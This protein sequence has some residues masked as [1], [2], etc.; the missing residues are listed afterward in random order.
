MFRIH[1]IITDA[2]IAYDFQI[3]QCIDQR[4][5]DSRHAGNALH[6]ARP[7]RIDQCRVAARDAAHRKLAGQ[8]FDGIFVEVSEHQNGCVAFGHDNIP[9]DSFGQHIAVREGPA[10]GQ[11]KGCNRTRSGKSAVFRFGCRL[12]DMEFRLDEFLHRGNLDAVQL[13]Q[14][15]AGGAAPHFTL[16]VPDGR[17]RGRCDRRFLEIVIAGHGNILA[18]HQPGTGNAV[19]Q[20]DGRQIVPADR[21]RRLVLQRQK[22]R[23]DLETALLR[24][25]PGNTPVRTNLKA[26]L[27]IACT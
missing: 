8:T 11:P 9:L 26:S 2:E 12:P 18:R 10:V 4:R 3:R 27:S 7:G 24:A 22:L 13:V 23:R 17:Q 6:V 1:R 14:Q 15:C 19:H 5:I 21:S 25:R 20:A 16:S